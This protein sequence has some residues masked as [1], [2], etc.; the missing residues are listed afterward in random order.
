MKEEGL[1]T[2]FYDVPTCVYLHSCGAAF[3]VHVV[4]EKFEGKNR[5][6][7]HR[8]IHEALEEVMGEIH[9]L[10]IKSAKTPAQA[11]TA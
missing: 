9:A 1:L 8:L 4:S 11:D 5:I 7:I 3:D 2:N 10:S 6:A